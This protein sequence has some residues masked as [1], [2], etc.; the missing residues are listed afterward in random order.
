M[1]AQWRSWTAALVHY[2]EAL[3]LASTD[4]ERRHLARRLADTSGQG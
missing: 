2:R 3:E 4:A 1:L